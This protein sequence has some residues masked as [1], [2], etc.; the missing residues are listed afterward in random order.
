VIYAGTGLQDPAAGY[1]ITG[2]T[3]FLGYTCYATDAGGSNATAMIN[4]LSFNTDYVNTFDSTGTNRTGIFTR[5]GA[6]FANSGLL[7][8][9]NIG[10]LPQAWK[11][12][13]RET[14]LTDSAET[15]ATRLGDSK[16]FMGTSW[17]NSTC[18]G[19]AGI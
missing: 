5:V 1:P 9:S 17:W 6:A 15:S 14:F 3:Q 7:V 4:F 13:V 12:A 11:H 8:R 19:K 18:T 16:L 2:T 10:G